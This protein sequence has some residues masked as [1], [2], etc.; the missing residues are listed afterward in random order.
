MEHL[1]INRPVFSGCGRT[2]QNTI[3]AIIS[4]SMSVAA[5]PIITVLTSGDGHFYSLN[6]RRLY[7]IKYLRENG[8]LEPSNTINVRLK[9]PLAREVKKYSPDRCSLTATIM[10]EGPSKKKSHARSDGLDSDNSIDDDDKDIIAKSSEPITERAGGGGETNLQLLLSS[11]SPELDPSTY[12]FCTLRPQK[13]DTAKEP[14][15]DI[16]QVLSCGI[17][18]LA[19]YHEK[20]GLTLI[21][22]RLEAEKLAIDVPL[23]ICPSHFKRITLKVHSSLDAVGLTAVVATKLAEGG[24]SANVVAAYYHDHIFVQCEKADTA[25]DLLSE[26]SRKL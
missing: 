15:K 26:F 24:I 7:V 10:R 9:T 23:E 22:E 5:L 11:L 3:E 2:I 17:V 16:E 4:G 25:M 6:N 13:S 12:A 8:Y 18:P 19:T 1:H 20:E 21:V 14:V